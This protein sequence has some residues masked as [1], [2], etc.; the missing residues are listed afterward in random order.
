MSARLPPRTPEHMERTFWER[1]SPEP[2]S[3][4]WLWIGKVDRYGYGM[5]PAGERREIL[6]H[7]YAVTSH[8]RPLPRGLVVDHLCRVRCCV[9]PQ[10]LDVVSPA[11]NVLR[12]NGFSAVNKA[13]SHCKCGRAYDRVHFEEGGNSRRSCRACVCAASA[14]YKAKARERSA[15]A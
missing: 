3:G 14:R 10:H 7:R 13:K 4:C 5:L 15:V 6:A 11:E 8:G 12:G 1:V 9:N 2:N